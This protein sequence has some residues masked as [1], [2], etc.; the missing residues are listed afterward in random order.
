[1]QKEHPP[2]HR[3]CLVIAASIAFILLSLGLLKPP[4]QKT[5]ERSITTREMLLDVALFQ[6]A[7]LRYSFLV[8]S[9]S[10]NSGVGSEI[11][12]NGSGV[13]PESC[14]WRALSSV[15]LIL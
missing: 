10:F 13:R 3:V 7:T 15:D 5:P 12:N 1:M 4:G 8:T 14:T 6:S 2:T 9:T 11:L